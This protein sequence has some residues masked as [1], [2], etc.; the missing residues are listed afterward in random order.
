MN[1]LIKKADLDYFLDIYESGILSDIKQNPN[2][3]ELK[4][5]LKVINDI[6]H[7]LRVLSKGGLR[8]IE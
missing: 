2:K 1:D 5:R 7:R 8:V 4:E 3:V 6:R